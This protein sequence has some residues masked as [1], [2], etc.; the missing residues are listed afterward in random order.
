MAAED[1]DSCSIDGVAYPAMNRVHDFPASES[2]ADGGASNRFHL[3]GR[4]RSLHQVLGG[5]T[6]ADIILWRRK[7]LSATILVGTT[8]AWILFEHSGFSLLTVVSDVLLI[9]IVGLFILASGAAFFNK[10]PPPIPELHMSE[11]MVISFASALRLEINKALA[12]AHDIALG[13]DLRVFLKVITI[14]WGLSV[15]GGWFHFLTMIYICIL[16]FHIVLGIY[17]SYEDQI[18]AYAKIAMDKTNK[19]YLAL[20]DIISRKFSSKANKSH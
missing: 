11:D 6:Y 15:V 10:Q 12:I 18:D 1:S 14:L 5:G 8:V 3:F 2:A 16:L 4:Q 19:H 20:N 13:K 9:L 17:E 7:Y